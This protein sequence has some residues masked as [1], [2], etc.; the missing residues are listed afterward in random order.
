M[1]VQAE[2]QRDVQGG[3]KLLCTMSY[4]TRRFSA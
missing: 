3:L 2:L 4:K 1:A